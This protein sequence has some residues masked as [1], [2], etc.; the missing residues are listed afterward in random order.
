MKSRLLAIAVAAALTSVAGAAS[1]ADNQAMP[2][3]SVPKS[4]TPMQS[5]AKDSLSLTPRQERI[6]WRDISK[7]AASQTAPQNFTASVGTTVPADVSIQ[8]VPAN[9]A[10][11][12]SALKSYDYALL[13]GKLLIVNPAD[14]KVVD[15]ISRRA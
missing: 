9:V 3:T 5:M 12:V 13:H 15:V 10:T 11:H 6:A 14:K 7:E 4:S 1:A 8:S 2:N